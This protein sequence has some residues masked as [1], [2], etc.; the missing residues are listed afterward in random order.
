MQ[1]VPDNDDR[2]SE[3][4]WRS[5]TWCL[6][7]R[8]AYEH[9]SGRTR[10]QA[11]ELFTD[12]AS[13]YSEDVMFMPVA[14]FPYYMHAYLDYLE[15]EAS[16][17]NAG[18]AASLFG[19]VEVRHEDFAAADDSLQHRVLAVLDRLVQRQQWYGADP[20]IWGDFAARAEGARMLLGGTAELCEMCLTACPLTELKRAWMPALPAMM[21]AS[22]PGPDDVRPMDLGRLIDRNLYCPKCRFGVNGRRLAGLLLMLTALILLTALLLLLR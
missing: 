5:E 21:I 13:R 8:N 20:E 10:E 12:N 3:D 17:G 7:A 22:D 14:C 4:D 1:S 19:L 18:A 16:R 6:D 2:P 11:V 15:S 9:L